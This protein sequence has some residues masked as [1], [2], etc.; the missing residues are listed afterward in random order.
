VYEPR[1]KPLLPRRAFVL[2]FLRHAGLALLL[3]AASLGAGV[4]AYMRLEHLA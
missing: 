3:L 4:F 2:R 1:G